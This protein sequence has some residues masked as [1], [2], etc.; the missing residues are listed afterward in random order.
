MSADASTAETQGVQGNNQIIRER[1]KSMN[2]QP[3]SVPDESDS[4]VS[5]EK[6]ELEPASFEN[7]D[8]SDTHCSIPE[9]NLPDEKDYDDSK[10]I[11]NEELSRGEMGISRSLFI[12]C[13][14]RSAR[15]VIRN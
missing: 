6:E 8:R 12:Y 7:G 11:S 10:G 5:V 14:I 4:N 1:S 13:M 3:A 9:I 2:I 15:H